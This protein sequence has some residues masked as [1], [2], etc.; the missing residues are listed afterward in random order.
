MVK[1]IIDHPTPD[2]I[3]LMNTYGSEGVKMGYGESKLKRHPLSNE[4]IMAVYKVH[5]T[6]PA[7]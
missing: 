5:K 7:S 2:N 4:R 3:V 1:I 6:P